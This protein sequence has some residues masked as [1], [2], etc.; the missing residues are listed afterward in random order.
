MTS[1]SRPIH[2]GGLARSGA[3]VVAV[4]L[5]AGCAEEGAP[6][7]VPLGAAGAMERAGAERAPEALPPQ[8]QER[9]DHG[10]AAYR[11]GDYEEALRHF[12]KAVTLEPAL[13]AGWYGIGMAELALD[14]PAAADSAMAVVHKLA[15]RVPRQHPTTGSP[16][17]AP[18]E[19]GSPPSEEGGRS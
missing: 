5:L 18:A 7:R 6:E 10:N 19:E 14:R 13:A 8:L 4:L 11:A 1:P 9:L 17:A 15:P 16:P 12:D 2:A 3:L